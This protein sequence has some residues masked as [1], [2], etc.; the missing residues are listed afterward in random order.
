M[1]HTDAMAQAAKAIDRLLAESL[2]RTEIMLRD[3]GGTDEEVATV[4][5]SQREEL[6]AWREAE[7]AKVA[8]WVSDPAAPSS[9]SH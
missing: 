6:S 4:M 1:T 9:E 3:H 2:E 8:R 5:Q 7:L